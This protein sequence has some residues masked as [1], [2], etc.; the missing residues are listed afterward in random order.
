MM[1]RLFL[2]SNNFSL[3]DE[4]F[5]NKLHDAQASAVE[6]QIISTSSQSLHRS[7]STQGLISEAIKTKVFSWALRCGRDDIVRLLLRLGQ[8]PDPDITYAPPMEQTVPPGC[9]FHKR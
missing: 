3:S 7:L 4:W 8:N 1:I 2:L 5:P 6:E 9:S